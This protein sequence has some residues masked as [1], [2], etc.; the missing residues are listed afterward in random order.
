MT[1]VR[2]LLRK[3]DRI[4]T[5]VDLNEICRKAVHLLRQDAALRRTRVDLALAP[6]ALRVVGDPVQLQ[7]VVINLTLNAL[8][9]AA[10]VRT[11]RRVSVST[12]SSHSAAEI[13]VRD[14]GPG[15]SLD[16]QQRLFEPF[17]TTKNQGLG[18]GLAI[19]RSIVERH[20]G[21]VH[22]EDG[23]GVGAVFR[24]SLPPC[25][26]PAPEKQRAYHFRR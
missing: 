20:H 22:A 11:N 12:T 5:V 17:F 9:A 15:L 1:H 19:V 3:E 2:V 21:R 26:A 23:L 18:M 10:A 6:N 16:S 24:V 14:N 25:A 4:T 13:V 7:Q 8:D